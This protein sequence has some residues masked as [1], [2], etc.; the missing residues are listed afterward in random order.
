MKEELEIDVEIKEVKEIGVKRR[1]SMIIAKM[2][3]WE[4]KREIMKRKNL[5]S[6]I[7]V[8][9]D[10]TRKERE[11]R[12]RLRKIKEEKVK[13]SKDVKVGYKKIHTGERWYRWNEKEERIEEENKGRTA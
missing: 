13:E 1:D 10:L 4:E 6:G 2:E 7:Y 5:K 11:V 3:K 8:E 9:D 12:R